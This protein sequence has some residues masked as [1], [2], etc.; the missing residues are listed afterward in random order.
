[1]VVSPNYCFLFFL[2]EVAFDAFFM[3]GSL[4]E[5]WKKGFYNS[6]YCAY[7]SGDCDKWRRQ[8]PQ[9]PDL[10]LPDSKT[11][12][13]D[14]TPIIMGDGKCS[15]IHEYMTEECGFEYGDCLDCQVE[16]LT[17]LGDGKCDGGE[18]NTEACGFDFGD[19]SECNHSVEDFTKV[20]DGTCNGNE[21][22]T[23]ACNYDG[24]DCEECTVEDMN[25]VG[26]GVC[27]GRDYMSEACSRD[28]GD[29]EL[30]D[31]DDP[32][33][34]GDGFCDSQYNTEACSFDG[35]DCNQCNNLVGIDNAAFIGDG[36]CDDQLNTEECNWDGGDCRCIVPAL[37]GTCDLKP[38]TML[39]DCRAA[40]QIIPLVVS[41]LVNCILIQNFRFL[42]KK[43]IV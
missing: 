18:Y 29:C 23:E 6:I 8:Y 2:S 19:C 16:D 26:N 12:Q 25:L 33:K 13:N 7:D 34:I 36:V 28:G 20:G 31:A 21:Y 42:V 5:F 37:E 22:S 27:N 11:Y 41:L 38:N 17:K 43:K 32:S 14:G 1:M 35:G 24:G 10:N 3:V 39:K 30:C 4:F 15:F 40:C 9:C